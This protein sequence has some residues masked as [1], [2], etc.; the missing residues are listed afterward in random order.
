MIR[1][2]ANGRGRPTGNRQ[3]WDGYASTLVADVA[4][5]AVE[6]G[7]REIILMRDKPTLYA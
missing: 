4:S 7:A 2:S 5:R 3:R 1:N 6:S